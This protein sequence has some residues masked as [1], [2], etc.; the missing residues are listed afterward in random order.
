MPLSNEEAGTISMTRS[1]VISRWYL[2]GN[3]GSDE[4]KD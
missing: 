1:G 4:D 3:N 2:D